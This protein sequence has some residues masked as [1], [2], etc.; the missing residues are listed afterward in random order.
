MRNPREIPKKGLK[1][2]YPLSFDQISRL[3]PLKSLFL[4]KLKSGGKTGKEK[5]QQF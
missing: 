4:F 1:S 3:I 2:N 5:L